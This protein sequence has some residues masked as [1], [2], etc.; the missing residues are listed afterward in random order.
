MPSS[1]KTR[2]SFGLRLLAVFQALLIF[3]SIF[4]PIPAFAVDPPP[5]TGTYLVTFVAGTTDAEQV[6]AL[7]AVFA[8]TDRVI[9]PL[10]MR[11]ITLPLDQ[12][13]VLASDP[14]LAVA[15][16][17]DTTRAIADAPDDPSY[18]SQWSL[19]MIG[20]DV[21]R[22]TIPV[23]PVT[24]AIVA[25]LDTGV[26]ASHPDLAG[27][28]VP[29]INILDEPAGTADSNGHGTAMAGI[30]AATTNNA[31]DI[32]GVGYAGVQVMPVTVLDA[33]GQGQD[34]DIV[35]GV[36][37]ATDNG[38]DVINMSFSGAGFSPALQAAIDYAWAHDV[39]VVAATGNGGS[40]APTFPAG[41]RG[42]I[43]VSNTDQTDALNPG[44]NYGED[45][46]LG[47]PGTDIATLATVAAG[48]GTTSVTGTSASSAEVAA[49]AA[50]LAAAD[51]SA[52]NGTIVGR[53]AR[54]ADPA[55]TAAETGNGRLNLA[56][57]LADFD[58]GY[59]EPAGAAPLG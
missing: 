54:N 52:S 10:N 50:L 53:L 14:I 17:A 18:A 2:R 4:S 12:F 6:A 46:F 25:V 23:T 26:D 11:V 21:A 20:W 49:A 22:D 3:A 57:A 15:P 56:R 8:T 55:G 42:V 19:P 59:V 5:T 28:L 48:G 24:P 37:W 33:A 36:V 30:I 58:T 45:T 34:S 7:D 32:A 16:E 13:E 44:S 40:S 27:Q 41:D 9:L 38:A 35:A 47:A 29:G 31:T 1:T 51:P 39:V 43:G